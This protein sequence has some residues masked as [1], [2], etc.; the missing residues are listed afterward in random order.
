MVLDVAAGRR[1][2]LDD[3]GGPQ[4]GRRLRVTFHRLDRRSVT[5]HRAAFREPLET[6]LTLGAVLEVR[7]NAGVVLGIELTVKK[8]Q[9]DAVVGARIHDVV[10]EMT[11]PARPGGRVDIAS[12]RIRVSGGGSY[13]IFSDFLFFPKCRTP[14]K[15]GRAEQRF[16]DGCDRASQCQAFRRIRSPAPSRKE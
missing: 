14:A 12:P 4:I 11:A 3:L 5:R 1:V 15:L 16:F 7:E 2:G 10:P 9:Q 13:K 6:L 8:L